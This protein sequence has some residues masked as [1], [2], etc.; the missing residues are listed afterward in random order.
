MQFECIEL[1]RPL[2]TI[3]S[4]CFVV[5]SCVLWFY[6]VFIRMVFENVL[7]RMNVVRYEMMYSLECNALSFTCDRMYIPYS[8]FSC[9]LLFWIVF[10]CFVFI[11][12]FYEYILFVSYKFPVVCS[13]IS[14][15]NYVSISC[16]ECERC[17]ERLTAVWFLAALYDAR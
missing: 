12:F 8:N 9:I 13:S 16:Q 4:V 1:S 10:F 14:L 15:L 11:F 7:L 2:F 3:F 17:V 5:I 6:S